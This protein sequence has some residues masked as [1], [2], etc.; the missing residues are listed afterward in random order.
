MSNCNYSD[1]KNKQKRHFWLRLSTYILG[2]FLFYAPF[3]LF[4]RT[5]KFF[6]NNPTMSDFHNLCLRMPIDWL[7]DSSQW[8]RFVAD[9]LYLSFLAIVG[10]AFLFG[11][12]FCGWLCSAGAITEYLC[13]LVPDRF[14][15]DF[16]GKVNPTPIR[17]GFLAG[18][19]LT[20]FFGGSVCCAFC[21]FSIFQ[22]FVSKLTGD[23][24]ILAYWSSTMIIT[25]VL[26]FF[27]FGLFMKGGRGW[28]NFGCPIGAVQ[29]LFY[30]I[31]AKFGFTYKLK[32]NSSKCSG[33]G[34]CIK[35]CSMWSITKVDQGKGISVSPY[36]CNVCLDCTVVCDRGALSYGTGAAET[37]ELVQ[38][39]NMPASG[40]GK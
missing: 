28:C 33:C 40:I 25:T 35:A 8:Y 14:K 19:I 27:L 26:W 13:K 18:F 11:P 32:Y 4:V 16:S 3:A 12:L 34:S 2:V 5:I 9:P 31:G 23:L 29:S 37:R 1:K 6:T 21:N 10:I 22:K 30:A 17:Y 38:L 39:D 36:T 15:I 20:P 24:Q 7:F